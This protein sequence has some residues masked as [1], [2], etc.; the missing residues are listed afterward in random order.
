MIF[1]YNNFVNNLNDT[2]TCI[3]RELFKSNDSHL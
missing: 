1:V 3:K 2:V